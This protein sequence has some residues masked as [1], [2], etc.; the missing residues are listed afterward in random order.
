MTLEAITR[1][2]FRNKQQQK[3]NIDTYLDGTPFNLDKDLFFSSIYDYLSNI[4]AVDLISTKNID[5]LV[6][7]D[8]VFDK[9][10]TKELNKFLKKQFLE[11]KIYT[12]AKKCAISGC[13][14]LFMHPSFGLEKE[15]YCFTENVNIIRL[16]KINN[17]I[18]S[19]QLL[20]K[21]I[22]GISTTPIFALVNVN[23]NKYWTS[24]YKESEI[25][26]N[27]VK[28]D[29][30][31]IQLK[32]LEMW[33]ENID[34]ASIIWEGL[35]SEHNLGFVPLFIMNFNEEYSP[36]IRNI[37]NDMNELFS[38]AQKCYDEA[39]YMGSKVKDINA[40]MSDADYTSEQIRKNQRLM[41]SSCVLYG[42]DII[43]ETGE[44]QI[45]VI[46]KQPIW[47]IL[48]DA[49]KQKINFILRKIGI[50]SDTDSKG[51]VQQ[52]IGEIIRQNEYSYNNQNYRNL[53]LQNFLQDMLEK[54][55]KANWNDKDEILVISSQSLGMSEMEKLNYVIQAKTNNLMDEARAMSILSGKN[56]IES[57]ELLELFQ[58][59][60]QNEE[61]EN[62]D[63]EFESNEIPKEEIENQEEGE[64]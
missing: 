38:I 58:L 34:L 31:A 47:Q 25:K 6:K 41:A 18:K 32:E 61:N 10:K 22:N 29:A 33:C 17:V 53:I 15:K 24:F 27:Q 51:T 16:T 14:C 8:L 59:N 56:Y 37:E 52:S 30:K 45:D 55:Y 13:S 23:E 28:E 12:L 3:E 7:T 42:R 39:H 11:K 20:V 50:S 48:N 19:A 1:Q 40:S 57:L 35:N 63:Q 49:F 4:A 60:I 44:V 2:D 26:D 9:D 5:A 21:F 36:L 64:E 62:V 46:T 43:E 54:V